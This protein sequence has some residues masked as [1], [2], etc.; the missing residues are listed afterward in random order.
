MYR[1]FRSFGSRV[2]GSVLRKIIRISESFDEKMI[3]M[4]DLE[5]RLRDEFKDPRIHF[6][7]NNASKSCPPLRA[8]PYVAATIDQ[9]LDDATRKYLASPDA[10]ELRTQAGKTT[11]V[12]SKIF[13]WYAGDFKASGGPLAFIEKYGPTE[14]REAIAGGKAKL[15][16]AD[17]DWSLNSAK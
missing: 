8:E 7:V 15:A 3:S 10:V 12:A 2:F 6:T 4:N 11:I 13:D 17:Y 5:K 16:F 9:Q 1:A 14:A